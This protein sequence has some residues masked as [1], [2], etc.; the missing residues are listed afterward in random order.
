VTR[1][2]EA[3]ALAAGA[4]LVAAAVN[5]GVTVTT[6]PAPVPQRAYGAVLP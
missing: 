4:L 6:D 3:A 2:L 5:L 1:I